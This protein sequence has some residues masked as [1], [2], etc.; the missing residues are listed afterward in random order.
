MEASATV[1]VVL[2]VAEDDTISS[3]E[4]IHSRSVTSKSNG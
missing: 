4:I 1:A 3:N 2:V